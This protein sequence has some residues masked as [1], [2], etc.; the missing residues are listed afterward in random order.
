MELTW[1]LCCTAIHSGFYFLTEP[2]VTAGR[3]QV[4][5]RLNF[6]TVAAQQTE[7]LMLNSSQ[8]VRFHFKTFLVFA[9][10]SYYVLEMVDT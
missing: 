3:V 7:D 8:S 2:K 4:E 9:T 1:E 6:A 10:N 5:Y